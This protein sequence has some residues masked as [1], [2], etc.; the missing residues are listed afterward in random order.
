MSTYWP[1]QS[2][3]RILCRVQ[4]GASY[5]ALARDDVEPVVVIEVGEGGGLAGA[6]IDHL[7]RER[8][9]GRA[10]L[11]VQC[12]ETGDDGAPDSQ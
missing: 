5:Q 4:A 9:I 3:S 12:S 2:M 10:A 8:N 7:D 6:R 11:R 1:F